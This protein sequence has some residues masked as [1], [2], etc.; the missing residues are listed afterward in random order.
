M[1][2]YQLLCRLHLLHK[3]KQLDDSSCTFF[4]NG[5]LQQNDE[6]FS[7][8]LSEQAKIDHVNN[9]YGVNWASQSWEDFQSLLRETVVNRNYWRLVDNPWHKAML[10]AEYE[11]RILAHHLLKMNNPVTLVGHSLGARVIYYALKELV[12]RDYRNVYDVILLGGA[13]GNQTKG[14]ERVSKIVSHKIYNCYS[15]HD[16]VLHYS[17]RGGSLGFSRAIGYYPIQINNKIN[18]IDCTNVVSSHFKWKENYA[19]IY[20]NF[21]VSK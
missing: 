4:V 17:Y 9:L 21:I 12:L 19:K 18:N 13:V 15:K 2:S 6:K 1:N 8:W 20:K 10:N 14:W 7:D 16:D 11:G 3:S 5:F